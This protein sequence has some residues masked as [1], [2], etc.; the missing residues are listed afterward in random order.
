MASPIVRVLGEFPSARLVAVL[1]WAFGL[2]FFQLRMFC[3]VLDLNHQS[4]EYQKEVTGFFGYHSELKVS[5]GE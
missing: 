2:H 3:C 5:E 1:V 4:G